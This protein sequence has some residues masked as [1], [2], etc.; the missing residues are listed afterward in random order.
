[1]KNETPLNY[2]KN[3]LRVIAICTALFLLLPAFAFT[4]EESRQLERKELLLFTKLLGDLLNNKDLRDEEKPYLEGL[5]VKVKS[6]ARGSKPAASLSLREC[7]EKL[8]NLLREYVAKN[9]RKRDPRIELAKF[10]IFEKDPEKALRHLERMGAASDKDIFWPLLTAYCHLEL[11]DFSKASKM[12]IKVDECLDKFLPLKIKR[13]LFCESIRQHGQ[14]LPLK[15][16]DIKAG[17]AIWIYL[18]IT[19]ATFSEKGPGQLKLHLNFGIELRDELQRTLWH[20]DNYSTITPIYQHPVKEVFAGL[21]YVI[22][23]DLKDGK[24]TLIITAADKNSDKKAT[25]D[26]IFQTGNIVAPDKE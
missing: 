12:L 9:H 18:D 8:K 13:A 26:I 19:G 21:D 4:Q 25:A 24:Y 17:K 22:P 6:L 10:Y 5:K 11:G 23:E 15:T 2:K 16:I 20:T 14:Y 7:R 3:P 1:M